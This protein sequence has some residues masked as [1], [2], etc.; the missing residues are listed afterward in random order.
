MKISSNFDSGNCKVISADSHDNIQLEIRTDTNS[1]KFQW[2]HFRLTGA[3]GYPCRI[4][5]LNAGMAAYPSWDDYRAVASYDRISWFRVPTSYKDGVLIINHTPEYNS[6]FYAY[7]APYTYEQHLKLIST[8]QHSD[9]CVLEIIG[10]TIQGR[11]IDMITVGSPDDY[12]KKVWIIA[13][14]HPG[15]TMA[16]WFMQG[17]MARLFDE[18]DAV[19]RLLLEKAVFYL[20]PNMNIDG[21]IAGNIRF[22][23]AGVDLNRAWAEPSLKSSPEVY[24]VKKYMENTGVDLFLDIHGDETLPYNFVSGIE[25]VPAYNSRLEDLCKTFVNDWLLINPDFQDT[26]KYPIN[27]PGKANLTIASK[28]VAQ[29]FN[30][31]AFTIEMPFKDNKDMP[32][33]IFGWSPERAIKFGES[34]LHPI[35][36]VV[37]KL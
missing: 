26:I 14:Q 22:N 17:L 4:K 20:V 25:G 7:F 33:M 15:E 23:A 21:G 27:E 11:D 13:R 37:N 9:L 3:E 12:K 10:E 18:D 32:D 8:A 2:F 28:N 34:V 5:I 24:Y 36:Q 30:C 29:T 19:T 16:E 31:P 35:M 6:I 1:D